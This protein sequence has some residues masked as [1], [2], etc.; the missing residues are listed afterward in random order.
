M[1]TKPYRPEKA[2]G[3]D[4]DFKRAGQVGYRM[5][6]VYFNA[7]AMGKE[8]VRVMRSP[9]GGYHVYCEGGYSPHEAMMLGD[10][11][12]R[13]RYW[14]G[15]GYTFTFHRKMTDKNVTIGIEEEVNPLSLPL[16]LVREVWKKNRRR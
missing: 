14:E 9:T 6:K 3:I 1:R 4:V 16:Y 5:L 7:L 10:C 11:K 8:G 2:E 13:L 15:Q 12:G